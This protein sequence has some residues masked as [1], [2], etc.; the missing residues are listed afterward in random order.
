MDIEQ[1]NKEIREKEIYEKSKEVI[2]C[3][4]VNLIT[5]EGL[6]GLLDTSLKVNRKQL[7]AKALRDVA[8]ELEEE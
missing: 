1:S 7:V 8:K 5:P 6:T 2:Q 3:V 4:A